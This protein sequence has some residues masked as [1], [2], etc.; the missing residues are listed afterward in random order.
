MPEFDCGKMHASCHAVCCGPVP[1]KKELL[2]LY[3]D[4]LMLPIVQILEYPGGEVV[5]ITNR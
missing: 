1:M 4:K 3:K 5:P 2:Q